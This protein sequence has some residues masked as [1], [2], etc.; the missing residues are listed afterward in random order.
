VQKSPISVLRIET[1]RHPAVILSEVAAAGV[2]SD[3]FSSLGWMATESKDLRFR[4]PTLAAHNNFAARM[5][6]PLSGH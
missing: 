4:S 2:P 5:G 6:H 1:W 3:R